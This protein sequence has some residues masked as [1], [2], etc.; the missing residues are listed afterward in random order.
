M[1]SSEID[2]IRKMVEKVFRE[3][4]DKVNLKEF[5]HYVN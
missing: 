4:E 2:D 3:S 5:D 1:S